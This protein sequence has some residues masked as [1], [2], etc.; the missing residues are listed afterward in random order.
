MHT[1]WSAFHACIEQILRY[2]FYYRQSCHCPDVRTFCPLVLRAG[3][4]V[5]LLLYTLVFHTNIPDE[6]AFLACTLECIE[7]I[8]RYYHDYT[9]L[10]STRAYLTVC[11]TCMH[12]RMHRAHLA[13]SSLLY[14]ARHCQASRLRTILS[15]HAHPNVHIPCIP[16]R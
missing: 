11:I 6:S 12:T 15:M 7:L 9:H 16:K 8:L 13:I 4:K 10:Y 14:T 5:L 1:W 3:H 2:Y